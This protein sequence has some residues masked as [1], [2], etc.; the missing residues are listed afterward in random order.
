LSP[1]V[2]ADR[3]A[4]EL[5]PILLKRFRSLALDDRRGQARTTV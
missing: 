2:S 3:F 1:S 4:R 5:I